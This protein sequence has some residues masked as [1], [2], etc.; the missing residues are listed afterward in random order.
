MTGAQDP[1]M[2]DMTRFSIA[3]LPGDG[4]GPE[5]IAPCLDLVQQACARV[6]EAAV[7]RSSSRLGGVVLELAQYPAGAQHYVR[8]GEALP[9]GTLRAA[10]AADAILLAAMGVPDIR[11]PD[12]TEISP[13]L[14]LRFE[15]GLYAGLR[16]VRVLPN[17]ATPLADPR[18]AGVDIAIVRESTEGLF[19]SHRC[20]T[21]EDDRTAR[22]TMVITRD[23]SERLFRFAF[24]LARQRRDRGRPGRVTCVDKA[25][26]FTSFAFFRRIFDEV[27]TT[28]PDIEADHAYVDAT[29]LN[30]I[31]R[32]WDYDVIVTENMF[33]DILSDLGAGLVGGMGMAPSA[34]IGDDHA[35]F[36]PSH[37]SAPDIAGQGIAN[38]TAMILSAAMML[39]WLGRRHRCASAALAGRC[40]VAATDAAYAGGR[41]SPVDL[42]GSDGTRAIAEAVAVELARLP[43]DLDLDP[44]SPVPSTEPKRSA[45]ILP[46]A[47]PDLL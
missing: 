43:L 6:T 35:L 9:G 7:H 19:A 30:L 5:V 2:A 13:Q 18:A 8:T 20:G 33:G 44:T 46:V 21:V 27:A 16:P 31:R 38:P 40:L 39:D 4:I 17:V 36:Q 41:L 47:R 11:Y 23:V 42:G 37:G 45:G 32:P 29:A 3:V 14:D 22:D 15:L 25:N 12:G 10:T 28:Y 34:D 24:D 1:A 26:V